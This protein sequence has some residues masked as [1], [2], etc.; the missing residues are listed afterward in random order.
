S[1]DSSYLNIYDEIQIIPSGR[2]GTCILHNDYKFTLHITNNDG[3]CYYRCKA[4]KKKKCQARLKY[5][6]SNGIAILLKDHDHSPEAGIDPDSFVGTDITDDIEMVT[7]NKGS[8]VVFYN[9]FK[10]LKSGE[11]KT[12]L[13]YRCVL[14]MKKCRSR[15][16]FNRENKTAMKNEI[17]HNHDVDPH[18]YDSFMSSA[19]ET[20]RFVKNVTGMK[21]KSKMITCVSATEK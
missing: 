13:Q 21:R 11:S 19:V 10:Y 8:T 14:Y 12:S 6:E 16:I 9:G 3:I 5:D 1:S 7:N 17:G 18:S 15:I 4:H 2:G 20:Q